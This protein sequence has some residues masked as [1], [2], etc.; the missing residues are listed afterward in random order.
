MSRHRFGRDNDTRWIVLSPGSTLIS[1]C[2]LVTDEIGENV[3]G[4]LSQSE[5]TLLVRSTCSVLR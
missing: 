2:L 1:C 4:F 5:R 3:L